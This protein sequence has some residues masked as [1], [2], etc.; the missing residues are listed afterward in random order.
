LQSRRSGPI[1]IRRIDDQLEPA[2]V[3]KPNCREVTHITRRQATDAES[4][5]QCHD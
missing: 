2:A 5:G 1:R 3:T 4:L